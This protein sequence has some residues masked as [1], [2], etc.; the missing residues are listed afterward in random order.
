M[1][2]NFSF[3]IVSFLLS[4]SK[5]IPFVSGIIKCTKISCKTINPANTEKTTPAPMVAKSNG[6]NEGII[7]PIVFLVLSS[8]LVYG[9][10][11]KIYL[12]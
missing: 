6:T 1:R 10:S 7:A 2:S 11:D 12:S 8:V 5:E 3:Y 4:S 9:L